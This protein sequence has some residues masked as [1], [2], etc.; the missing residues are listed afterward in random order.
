MVYDESG[1]IGKRYARQDESGTP[2]CI[3]VDPD[4]EKTSKV[5]LRDRDSTKQVTVN[6]DEVVDVVRKVIRGEALVKLGKL[7]ET[8]VK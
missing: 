2:L 1:S 4:T 8:R 7:V 3:T 5:T 6:V